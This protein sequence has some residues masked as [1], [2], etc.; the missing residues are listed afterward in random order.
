MMAQAGTN[1][2]NGAPGTPGAAGTPGINGIS[3]TSGTNGVSIVSAVIS[4]GDLVLRLSNGG[5]VDAGPLP[6]AGGGS[7]SPNV[8]D[9]NGTVLGPFAD[10]DFNGNGPEVW[11]PSLKLFASFNNRLNSQVAASVTMLPQTLWSPV[12]DCSVL[13]PERLGG[14]NGAYLFSHVWASPADG[15]TPIQLIPGTQ[16]I[17]SVVVNF[18]FRNGG[19]QPGNTTLSNPIPVT[20]Q[21]VLMPTNPVYLPLKIQ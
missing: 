20:L 3:G 15:Y 21:T 2:A 8:L 12:S 13:Y 16:T 18:V 9:A 17:G 14:D 11:L 10:F 5:N 4:N 1:G 19:C 7:S 6:N